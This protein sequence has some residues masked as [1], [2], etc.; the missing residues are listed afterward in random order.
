MYCDYCLQ[1]KISVVNL[2]S[3]TDEAVRRFAW[4]LSPV[5]LPPDDELNTEDN[6]D[7]FYSPYMNLNTEDNAD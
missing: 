3:Q 2:Y 4:A 6:A 1:N 5:L 7:L